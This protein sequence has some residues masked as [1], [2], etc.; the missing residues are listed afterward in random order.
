MGGCSGC[1]V[2]FHIPLPAASLG[3]LLSSCSAGPAQGPCLLFC[4][5]HQ[6]PSDHP[7]I[8]SQGSPSSHLLGTNSLPGQSPQQPRGVGFIPQLHPT[9]DETE[10]QGD[11]QVCPRPHSKY[12]TELRP[13]LRT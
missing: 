11:F 4:F 2:G 12:T 5:L 10:A 8:S 3:G 7:V 9:E 13:E 6:D 1:E